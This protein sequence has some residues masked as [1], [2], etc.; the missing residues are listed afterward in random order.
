MSINDYPPEYDEPSACEVCHKDISHVTSECVCPECPTCGEV[1]R[2]DCFG[3]HVGALPER[4][5]YEVLWDNGH[6]CDSLGTFD[7]KEEAK[8]AGED[9]L[10][11]AI[12]TDP[13]PEEAEEDYSY[14]ILEAEEAPPWPED[15]QKAFKEANEDLN[16][17]NSRSF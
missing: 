16:P 14:E 13:S 6:A 12:G 15:I 10:I 8:I 3:T 4:F 17:E 11:Q 2:L 9:W 7:T 5:T 1:G